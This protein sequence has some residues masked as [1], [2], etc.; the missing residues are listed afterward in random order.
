MVSSTP[1]PH[2]TLGKDMVPILQETG[3]APGPVWTGG[4]S[5]PH[6][7]SIPDRPARSQSLHGL[8]Y[9][10]HIKDITR[11]NCVDGNLFPSLLHLTQWEDK[12]KNLLMSGTCHA[13]LK[14]TANFL[15][16]SDQWRTSNQQF[17]YFVLIKTHNPK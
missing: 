8:S 14:P 13:L 10:T 16:V 3:W 15:P 5:C 6:R 2:F 4:K 12:T 17:L 7:N 1:R 9:S 11:T